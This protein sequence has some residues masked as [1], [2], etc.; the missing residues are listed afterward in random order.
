MERHKTT[1]RALARS[2]GCLILLVFSSM[3]LAQNATLSGKVTDAESGDILP[4]ANV[5][6]S[7]ADVQTGAATLGSG[8]YS[9]KN[10]PPG[11]YTVR[12]TYIGY[13]SQ[14]MENVT[15]AAGE[16]KTLNFAL[17]LTGI[18]V[19]P[20]SISASRR[21][22][23]VLE[24][25]ASISVL[26]ARELTQQVAP[27]SDALLS[28]VTGID[29][30]QTGIDRREIVL[31]GFNNAFSG[32]TYIL[33]D[34]R[35]AAVPSLDVNL[36]S[37]MP[38]LAI[39]LE[40]VEI[41]RGPGSALYGAG[42][43]AGVIHYLSKDPFNHRSTTASF[44]G[45]E[46][47]SIAGHFRH[48]NVIGEKFGY[49][50]TGQYA[51]ADDWDYDI[52]DPED[53][54]QLINPVTGD[55]TFFDRDYQKLN[56]NG[57]M[58]F[59][60][61]ENVALIFNGGYSH[62][63]ATVLSG[64]GTVQADNY[65]YIYGQVR[66][67]AGKFF[68]QAYLNKNDAGDSF[69][70]GQLQASGQDLNVVD[71][72]TV[73]NLQAQYDME[74]MEGKEQV[75]V[76]VD[77]D[78]TT[79]K[80]EGT[81]YGRNEDDDLISEFGVYAQ[82]LT[83]ISPKL[84][85]TIAARLDKNN[86]EDDVQ[87]SP[88]A[89][90]VFKPT[91]KH[92]FRVTY[93]RAYALPGG[94]SLFLDI[95][96]REVPLAPGISII[97]RGRGSKDGFTFDNARAG[98]GITASGLLPVPGIFGQ[99]VFQY[100]GP[101]VPTQNVPLAAVYGIVYAGLAATPPEQIQALLVANGFPQLPI[102]VIQ[103]LI[104]LLSPTQTQVQGLGTSVLSAAPVDVE[105]L[106]STITHSIEAGYKGLLGERV[107]FAIDGYYTQKKNFVSGVTQLTPLAGFVNIAGELTPA[108]AAAIQA[109]AQ[110]AG[111]LQAAGATPQQVAGIIVGLAQ[112]RG[113]T[114]LPVGVVQPDQNQAPGEIVGAYRNFGDIDFW[115][116]DI[117]L[118]IAAT[119]RLSLFGNISYVSDDF[120]DDD[121]LGEPGS[122]LEL[123]LNASKFKAKGGFG[124]NLPNGLSFNAAGRYTKGFPVRSGPYEG[125]IENYFLLDAGAGY[126]FG[127]LAPGMRID[128]TVQNVLNNEH[129]EFIG[130]PEIGRLALARI[131]Y[132]F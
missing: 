116:F 109:N 88:R 85:L 120:F 96:G 98:G 130:A 76:G 51:Q 72:S 20:I 55:T 8:E 19:N 70:Y 115:G 38:N 26:E 101:G 2:I 34:Y 125:D 12:V 128:V 32:A 33:T 58:E 60:L 61:K 106:K 65:G 29:M 1:S 131:T 127:R 31:R 122:G 42:V 48:A 79:P 13:E 119:N 94:N 91:A 10:L 5:V 123:A 108:L 37:V 95:I 15:L 74:F 132:T 45:G 66:L 68:A 21:S 90:I 126:D 80:T 56:I 53:R 54:A 87:I 105:P 44:S 86:I 83:K 35:R 52:N 121:E 111:A 40:K 50:I 46:R 57:L 36:H 6:V 49:K 78:R 100:S 97:Q 3:V 9:V 25:P 30:A 43:D 82:S 84:D 11:A 64:I 4:G 73:L 92:N 62:L 117:A 114:S 69:V 71:N 22:E 27:S 118:Q 99:N 102:P 93:N 17:K 18:N 47:T 28:N 24:A 81:I 77:Y 103:Q 41:V 7:S 14:V 107:L 39:D 16:N 63:D 112:Q 75:I 104:A 67:Q 129:R 113:I 124:Y 89:A 59:R 110:L 23:K